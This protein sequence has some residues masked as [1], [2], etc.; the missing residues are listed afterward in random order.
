MCFQRWGRILPL[1]WAPSQAPRVLPWLVAED[2]FDW[3]QKNIL[4]NNFQIRSNLSSLW[5]FKVSNWNSVNWPLSSSSCW[6]SSDDDEETTWQQIWKW[7]RKKKKSNFT[8]I[9]LLFQYF[10]VFM[11]F[12]I[13]VFCFFAAFPFSPVVYDDI[14]P[15]HNL[16]SLHICMLLLKR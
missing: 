4:P 14:L 15:N 13:F 8:F 6:C 11:F 5:A 1:H 12:S 2:K 3:C 9:L 10:S 16:I 7:H